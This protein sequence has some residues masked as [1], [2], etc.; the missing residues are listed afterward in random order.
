MR[1][2]RQAPISRVPLRIKCLHDS[3]SSDA[4]LPEMV[5]RQVRQDI[6][7]GSVLGEY[8]AIPGEARLREPPVEVMLRGRTNLYR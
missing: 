3:G 5:F 7:A 4:D 1:S 6:E 8:A 2:G